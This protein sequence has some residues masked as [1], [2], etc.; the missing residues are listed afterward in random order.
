[1]N[2]R[3]WSPMNFLSL[4]TSRHL[5]E[6]VVLLAFWL[7]PAAYAQPASRAFIQNGNVAIS[8]PGGRAFHPGHTLVRFR[9]GASPVFH[10]G[11]GAAVRFSALP[12]LFLVN[13]PPGLSVAE[14]V[15]RYHGNPNVLYAEPDYY[16][17]AI[18]TTPTDP[19]WSQQYDMAK[20][21]APAAWDTQTNAGDVIVAIIDTGIDFTHPDLQGNLWTDPGNSTTHGFT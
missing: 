14:A 8:G 16:V 4:L 3:S 21:A 13:N 15:N 1:M 5:L 7:A 2:R 11:S 20:I 18:T 12:G 9:P 17:Q 6:M 19:Q 10:P